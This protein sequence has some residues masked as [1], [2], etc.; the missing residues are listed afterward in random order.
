MYQIA[1]SA[2]HVTG[3]NTLKVGA[4]WRYGPYRVNTN[5][6]ADLVQRYRGGVPDSVI[7]YNTPQRSR[8]QLNADLGVYVQDSWRLKRLTL[9]PGVRYEYF[10]VSINA[11]EVEA[12][13]FV[14]FR[15]YPEQRDTPNWSNI[16]PRFGAVYD[17]FGDARTALRFGVNRYNVSY[18]LNATAPYD[19]MALRS[20]TR[21]WADC[22]YLPGTSTCDPARIGGPGYRDNIAQDNEIGPVV[23]PF[24]NNRHRR[25]GPADAT[26]TSSTT[27]V[28]ITRSGPGSRSAP[29]GTGAAGTT[30]R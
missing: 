13:R 11:M 23:M 4:Q 15:S 6:N 25:P 8:Q 2:S 1:G 17:L 12:G 10:N 20:D 22:A 28:S 24:G 5:V 16:T 27:L 7:V 14:G 9:N 3:S 21:N 30:C 26:T 18:G 29:R 19:P